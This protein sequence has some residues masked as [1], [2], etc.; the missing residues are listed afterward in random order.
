[1][2]ILRGLG[3]RLL[4]CGCVAGIYETYDGHVVTIIDARGSACAEPAHENGKPVPVP[5]P[6]PV[7]STS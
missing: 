6:R 1:M 7:K 4:A 2:R 3:S 5:V